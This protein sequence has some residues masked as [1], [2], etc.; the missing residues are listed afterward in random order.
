MHH[1]IFDLCDSNPYGFKYFRIW[2][3]FRRDLEFLRNS[4]VFYSQCE[5]RI[6]KLS[7]LKKLG[8]IETEFENTKPVYQGPR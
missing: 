6:F 7:F 4:P 2:F 8:E 5:F 1:E 3:R